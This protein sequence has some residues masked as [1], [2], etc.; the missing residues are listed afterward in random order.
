MFVFLM[1]PLYSLSIPKLMSVTAM[2]PTRGPA[3]GGTLIT[4]SGENLGIGNRIVE[5]VVFYSS[6]ISVWNCIDP[7][8]QPSYPPAILPV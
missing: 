5:R 8:I 2:E 7:T 3:L 1:L 4:F 6:D